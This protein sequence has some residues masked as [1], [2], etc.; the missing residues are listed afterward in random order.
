MGAAQLGMVLA[1]FA[2]LGDIG[3]LL[4]MSVTAPCVSCLIVACL[5]A[6]I[7][8]GFRQAAHR[9]RSGLPNEKPGR[10]ALLLIW[11]LLF[12]VNV[13]TAL[14]TQADTVPADAPLMERLV[15]FAKLHPIATAAVAGLAVMVGPRKLMRYG[16]LALPLISKLK[17]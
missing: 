8:C 5:F 11:G 4:L 7:Y 3:L 6:M 14:R 12:I 1:G 16:G 17:R 9:T 10:S 15:V 13:G 2:L